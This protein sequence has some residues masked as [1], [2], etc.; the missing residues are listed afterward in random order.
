VMISGPR[1]QGGGAS[2][3]LSM[4]ASS[5]G[6]IEKQL[7]ACSNVSDHIGKVDPCDRVADGGASDSSTRRWPVVAVS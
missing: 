5:V 4:Y 1:R 7:H 6:G 3:S 2:D